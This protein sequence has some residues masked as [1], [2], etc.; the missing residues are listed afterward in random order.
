MR[1]AVFSDVHAN[2]IALEQFLK[3]TQGIVDGYLCLGDVVNYGPWNDECLEIVTHLPGITFLE[4]NHERLFI[5]AEDLE[6]ES[7]LVRDFSYVSKTF[8]SRADLIVGLPR[9]CQLLTFKCQHTIGDMKIY[10]D[11]SIDLTCDYIIGHKHHQF[12]I[13]K[14]GFVLLNPG[15]VGQNR[16]WI[17][18]VDY[19]ILDMT[20]GEVQMHSIP[21]D[22][23]SFL[24]ELRRRHYPKHCITYYANKPR[25][26]G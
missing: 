14:S 16:K 18:M 5:D 21:Y 3:V 19:L 6:D 17:D 9:E 13:E 1:I 25:H 11:T 10:P 15:S 26:N 8:F 22:F 2:L 7:P 20:S 23:D 24:S 12:K 4:G